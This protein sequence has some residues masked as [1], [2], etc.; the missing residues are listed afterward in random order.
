MPKAQHTSAKVFGSSRPRSPVLAAL[1]VCGA[2]GVIVGGIFLGLQYSEAP[3]S[4]AASR[5]LLLMLWLGLFTTLL[6]VNR[7]TLS[8]V[9]NGAARRF[10]LRLMFAMIAALVC[11]LAVM[12]AITVYVNLGGRL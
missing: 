2:G 3:I 9:G 4:A 8:S 10:G 11:G 1:A 7:G 6:Y 5:L 12:A